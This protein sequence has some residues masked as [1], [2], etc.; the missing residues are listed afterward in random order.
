[1]LD[2]RLN[3]IN[4]AISDSPSEKQ[5]I[6]L[7]GKDAET[8]KVLVQYIETDE[9]IPN[10]NLE[11]SLNELEETFQE[12]PPISEEISIEITETECEP[13]EEQEIATIQN[14]VEAKDDTI[15]PPKT[16][17]FPK[18]TEAIRNGIEKELKSSKDGLT[19]KDLSQILGFEYNRILGVVRTMIKN[20]IIYEKNEIINSKN[21]KVLRLSKK[22]TKSIENIKPKI[23]QKNTAE[24]L[25][26]KKNTIGTNP[27]V[28]GGNGE[29]TPLFT[30]M[31]FR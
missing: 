1:M 16:K 19:M 23:T 22:Q 29:R 25:L 8:F 31:D 26:K 17:T 7:L 3:D 11:E 30:P 27:V 15:K 13:K 6:Y 14:Q 28:Q 9:S 5:L 10:S 24:A 20:K 18:K 2:E 21:K 4:N 12:Q